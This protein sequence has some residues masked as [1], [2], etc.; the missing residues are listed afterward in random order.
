MK[1]IILI[2]STL[3]FIISSCVWADTS[4]DIKKYLINE[5]I[6]AYPGLKYK[7][8]ITLNNFKNNLIKDN[9]D[10]LEVDLRKL[11]LL[12]SNVYKVKIHNKD[13]TAEFKIPINILV[14]ENIPFSAVTINKTVTIN[15]YMVKNQYIDVRKIAKNTIKDK[16]L[17]LNT[18]LTVD[19]P[20]NNQF[21]DWMIKR[22]KNIVMLNNIKLI[23]KAGQT[24]IET[25]GV[26]LNDGYTGS[27]IKVR[28][29]NNNSIFE[30]IVIDENSVMVEI[31]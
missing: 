27:K 8:T 13:K 1:K 17:L 20:A 10:Y 14:E 23:I 3:T 11:S 15:E 28:E 19:Q 7:I 12:G 9:Y 6:K 2:F 16:T 24:M 30:G 5:L 21:Y 18:K 29:L 25:T 26:A 4:S 22:E 31:K